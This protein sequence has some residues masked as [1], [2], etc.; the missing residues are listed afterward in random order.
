[1]DELNQYFEAAK[2]EYKKP[3]PIDMGDRMMQMIEGE[4]LGYSDEAKARKDRQKELEDLNE[5]ITSLKKKLKKKRNIR[6]SR[7]VEINQKRAEQ[8]KKI[9]R[10]IKECQLRIQEIQMETG[11]QAE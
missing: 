6:N 2:S 9:K 3:V 8:R 5:K 11:E 1:M 7:M 4:Y 10:Q